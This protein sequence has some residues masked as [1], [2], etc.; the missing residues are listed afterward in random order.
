MISDVE[1][2]FMCLLVICMSSLEKCPFRSSTQFLV[3]IFVV[4]ILSCM[5]HLHIL[6]INPLQIITFPKIFS[7]SVGCLFIQSM[8]SFVVQKLLSLIRYHLFIF[9][10]VSSAL[11]DRFKKNIAMIYVN[12]CSAYVL[13]W[14]VYGFRSQ[15]QFFN[16]FEVYFC[17]WCE[18]VF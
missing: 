13:F 15:I 17:I 5:R 9:A 18:K 11:G 10:F 14:E 6:D 12:E 1:H 8:I 3:E 2:H 4:L 16:P 7:H